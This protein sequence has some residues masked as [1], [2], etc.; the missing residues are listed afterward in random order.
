MAGDSEI[1]SFRADES[2]REQVQRFMDQRGHESQS[3]AT[4]ELVEVGLREATGPVLH[5]W[6][7][8]TTTVALYFACTAVTILIIGYATTIATIAAAV[9]VALAF[10]T[11]GVALV[12]LVELAR[13]LTGQNELGDGLWRLLGARR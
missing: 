5:N 11:V 1:L 6:R 7:E 13:V 4:R 3:D 12:G 8:S 2:T 10:V 9:Q